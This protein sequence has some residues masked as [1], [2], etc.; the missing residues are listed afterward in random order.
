M[1]APAL[2][3]PP[4]MQRAFAAR[5]GPDQLRY[6]DQAEE[7]DTSALL[8]RFAYLLS[9]QRIWATQ[10]QEL[11]DYILPRKNSIIVQ[12]LPGTKRTQRLFD[13]TALDCRDKLAR[14]INGA[15]TSSY[16]RWFYLLTESRELNEDQQTG[17]WLDE[18]GELLLGD[19][20]RS[21]FTS[22]TG[23]IYTDLVTF[24]NGLMYAEEIAPPVPREF[25]GFLFRAEQIGRY[26]WS[27]G[28]DG[29]VDVIFREIFMTPEAIKDKWPKTPTDKLDIGASPDRERSVIHCCVPDPSGKGHRSVY[30]LM[31]SK[32]KLDEG[33]YDDLP[34]FG[35][36]WS[37]AS[38]ETYGR[39]PSDEAI[40]D[41]RSI[42]KMA[43]M[44]LRVLPLIVQPPLSATGD[45]VGA[46]RLVPL[47]I[48]TV[49]TA[50]RAEA[51]GPLL[52]PGSFDLRAANLSAERLE[53]KIRA[54]YHSEE[55]QL[56]N[57]PQMTAEEVRAR[58]DQMLM[59]LGPTVYGRIEREFLHPLIDWMFEKRRKA[60]ALPP[61]P[62]ALQQA[63]TTGK[64]RLA[65]RYDG[66]IARAQRATDVSAM[67]QLIQF[68]QPLFPIDPSLIDVFDMD[69]MMR[70]AGRKLGV[71]PQVLLDKDGTYQVR[72]VK[73]Q[74]AA[75]QQ[76]AAQAAQTAQS[77]GQAAPLLKAAGQAPEPGSP[78]DQMQ[79]QQ[80]AQPNAGQ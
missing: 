40:P 19:L 42:N 75:Q 26:A 28:K 1:A 31:Q 15:L 45:V 24:A 17:I 72:Q 61:L 43:E 16:I 22:E 47:G 44:G 9:V 70:V 12:R 68:A 65:V 38:G 80:G 39:G 56:P 58:R 30:I 79:N 52:P 10:W 66:P 3:F 33:K 73:A 2:K 67:S 7:A 48:T 57:G 4:A 27:E 35:V 11:A 5:R 50:N 76:Q 78:L 54:V 77:A 53:A 8:K 21:N 46:P 34:F 13:S 51:V 6:F 29:R 41:I 25:G 71:P 63:A 37:V 62:P 55:L 60:N 59:L 32:Y 64:V 49:R 14:A 23:E 36:R 18:V 20:N 69:E 74:Q